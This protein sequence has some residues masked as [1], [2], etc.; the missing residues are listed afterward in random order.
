MRKPRHPGLH[1]AKGRELPHRLI[2]AGGVDTYAVDAGDGPPVVLVHGYGDT[3]DGWRRVVPGLLAAGHRVVA[4]DVPPFGRSGDPKTPSL[5][6]FYKDFFPEL[7]ERLELER[8]TVIGHSLGGA[9]S[10]HLTLQRPDLVERLGLV[11]PAGLGKAPP[12]WWHL[13]AGYDVAWKTA[14]SIPNPV[15]APLIRHGMTRFLD[16]RL[17]HDPRQMRDTIDHLVSLHGTRKSFDLLLS[18]GRCCIDSYT[19]TLLEDSRAIGVPLFMVWGE[20]DGLVPSRHASDF[21][22]IHPN[23]HVHVFGDCGHYPHIELPSRFNR[24]LREWLGAGGAGLR[25]AAEAA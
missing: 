4:V 10:L 21:G 23:A 6:D 16:W 19:G 13:I 14:L 24:V 1:D 11:A 15:T 8:A 12:W 18:A 20:H 3:A 9:I 17:F 7:F 5:L 2:Q 25:A 22:R